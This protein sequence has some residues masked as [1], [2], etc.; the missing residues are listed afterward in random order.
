MSEA[1]EPRGDAC[2]DLPPARMHLGS[3][4]R[5]HTGRSSRKAFCRSTEHSPGTRAE[6]SSA[7]FVSAAVSREGAGMPQDGCS[8]RKNVSLSGPGHASH[9]VISMVRSMSVSG[10]TLLNSRVA[11][12][13]GLWVGS[14]MSVLSGLSSPLETVTCRQWPGW[15]ATSGCRVDLEGGLHDGQESQLGVSLWDWAVARVVRAAG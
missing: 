10:G 3:S 6:R 15:W 14:E 12:H 2:G 13:T 7:P 1:R 4:R 11:F 8:P 5:Y 9:S